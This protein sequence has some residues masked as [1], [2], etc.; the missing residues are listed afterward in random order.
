M[1]LELWFGLALGFRF[2]ALALLVLY[3]KRSV[4]SLRQHRTA[5]CEERGEAVIRTIVL[6][7][8]NAHAGLS[9]QGVSSRD[10]DEPGAA[11]VTADVLASGSDD[12]AMSEVMNRLNIEPGV[13]SVKWEKAPEID[14]T[15]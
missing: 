11:V 10:G 3:L 15:V 8:V 4:G 9:V 1:P 14:G 13:R 12:K 7:H 6:R 5:N 2:I